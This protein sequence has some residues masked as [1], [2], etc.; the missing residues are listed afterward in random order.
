[1]TRREL[2][3]RIA[4]SGGD[5]GP[6]R[7]SVVVPAYNVAAQIDRCLGS[8][9]AQTLPSLDVI[10]VNDGSTD[11]FAK[12]RSINDKAFRLALYFLLSAPMGWIKGIPYSDAFRAP[13]RQPD[14]AELQTTHS[15]K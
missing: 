12:G 11:K 7:V 1:M 3:G 6:L 10:V 14:A 5:A 9:A 4:G 13:I 15:P 8:L 2:L